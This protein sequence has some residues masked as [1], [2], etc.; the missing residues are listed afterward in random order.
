MVPQAGSWRL[1]AGSLVR[2]SLPCPD[3][4]SAF[5]L[6]LCQQRTHGVQHIREQVGVIRLL[7]GQQR[8]HMLT[9]GRGGEAGGTAVGNHR[10]LCRA[11]KAG[12]LA[13]PTID[14]GTDNADVSLVVQ[15]PCLHGPQLPTVEE[16][17]QQTLGQIVQMLGQGQHPVA[18]AAAGAVHNA[19][20]HAGTVGTERIPVHPRLG[21]LQDGMLL[22]EPGHTQAVVV[23][24]ERAGIES[25]YLRIDRDDPER[26]AHRGVG[27][28][29]AQNS[30]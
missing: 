15:I 5:Q 21:L 9:P 25:G 18:L 3:V 19:P 17:Q 28:Q 16:R 26:E 23:G 14:Q 24:F 29:V 30:E 22:I 12:G 11:R 27:L 2:R 10:Q 7:A 13:F 4:Y 1:K 20:L 6:P 8:F